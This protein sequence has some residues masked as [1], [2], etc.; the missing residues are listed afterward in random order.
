MK[1]FAFRRRYWKLR[2]R[3]ENGMMMGV[4]VW[5]VYALLPGTEDLAELAILLVFVNL[6]YAV[7]GMAFYVNQKD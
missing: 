4:I 2:D 1:S 5:F 7:L 6:V 3:L